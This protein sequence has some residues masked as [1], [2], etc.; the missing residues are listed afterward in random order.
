MEVSDEPQYALDRK[1]G[2]TQS[3]PE[4]FGKEKHLLFLP[5]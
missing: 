3:R 2:G 1:L 4:R 5:A